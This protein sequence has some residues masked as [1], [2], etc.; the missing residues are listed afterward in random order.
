MK[1]DIRALARE[2]ARAR[3]E[4]LL[5]ELSAIKRSFPDLANAPASHARSLAPRARRTMTS[6]EREAIGI[7]MKA[8]WAARRATGKT[9]GVE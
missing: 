9:A 3:I 8:Y 6:A 1:I 2:G 4:E 5:A 7:R